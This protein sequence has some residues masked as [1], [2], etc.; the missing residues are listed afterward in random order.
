MDADRGLRPPEPG[1]GPPTAVA[2]EA[3]RQSRENFETVVNAVSDYAIFLLDDSGHIISWNTGAERIKG[4]RSHQIIGRHFSVFYPSERVAAGWPAKELDYVREFGRFEE[5]NWRIRADGSRFWANVVITSL[6]APEGRVRGFLKITRDLTSR[7]NAEEQLRA[8]HAELEQ[9]VA[10]RTTEL[11]ETNAALSEEI[12]SRRRLES[13]LR[14]A[15]RQL[16]DQHRAKDQFLAVLAH[17]LRNPM[18]P[19]RSASEMLLAHEV[20][21]EDSERALRIVQR[22]TLQLTRLVDDL[23]DMAR[24]TRNAITLHPQTFD[25]RQAVQDAVDAIR[26]LTL[27]RDPRLDVRLPAEPVM[28]TG[29]PARLAQVFGNL[30]HNAAK[31]TPHAGMI[32]VSLEQAIP[33]VIV[34]VTDNG[35]GMSEDDIGRIF[36]MFV[37]ADPG[38][39]AQGG[40]G[41]GLTLARH[42]VDLHGGRLEVRSP[43]PGQGSSFQVT[44]PA[45]SG[46]PTS[47]SA[48]GAGGALGRQPRTVLIADDNADAVEALSMVLT[49][50]GHIVRHVTE[51]EDAIAEAEAFCPEFVLLDIGLPRMNGY[52]VAQRIR[53][54]PFGDHVVLV[55]ITGWGQP[56]DRERARQAGFDYHITKPADPAAIVRLLA[57]GRPSSFVAIST[58]YDRR[59]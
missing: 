47:S 6:K 39:E 3:L 19:I 7:R 51:P 18:A 48:L 43:G 46:L 24:M 56:A 52:E 22:Q 16:Q 31:F 44:L 42:L 27:Q 58:T 57:A 9:R 5:E 55:A 36:E 49:K 8:A 30:L 38:R 23:L 21:R 33:S 13:D 2:E 4:Y 15:I 17:E 32:T 11:A 45:E 37:Q 14:G 25:V 59:P 26:P 50:S 41:I 12:R 10:V 29:D 54:M 20:T 1:E 35:T 28:I 34:T 40:L 53:Q